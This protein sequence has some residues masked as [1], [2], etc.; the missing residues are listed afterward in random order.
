MLTLQ[1][2]Y[3]SKNYTLYQIKYK[4]N[5]QEVEKHVTP[6]N[7]CLIIIVL[8][9]HWSTNPPPSFPFMA[10]PPILQVF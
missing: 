9:I 7:M 2:S 8:N 1:N 4:S 3:V 5:P 6:G 10:E